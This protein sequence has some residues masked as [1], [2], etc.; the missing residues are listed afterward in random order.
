MWKKKVMILT[1]TMMTMGIGTTMMRT[2][3]TIAGNPASVT[4]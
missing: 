1:I 4:S 2:I 3:A